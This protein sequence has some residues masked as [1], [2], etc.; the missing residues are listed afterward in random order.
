MWLS[1]L[2]RAC[3]LKGHRFDS[4][5]LQ[6]GLPVGGPRG[7]RQPI[8]VSLTHRCF[9]P[10][11]S[12]S[13]PPSKNKLIKSLKKNKKRT[14]SLALARWL[15]GWSIILYQRQKVACSISSQGTY[16]GCR[17]DPWLGSKRMRSYLLMLLSHTDVSLCL[18]LSHFPFLSKIKKSVIG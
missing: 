13:L 11:L 15:I 5:G 4:L 9:S 6:A 7:K 17:F 3:K 10:S 14:A 2:S 18:S 8:D 16:L 12:P 1:R